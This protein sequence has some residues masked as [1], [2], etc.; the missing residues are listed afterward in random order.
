[1]NSLKYSPNTK[2]LI[3]T[4]LNHRANNGKIY[5]KYLLLKCFD[6]NNAMVI[7]SLIN[8]AIS[9]ENPLNVWG[10]GSAIR[11]FIYSEDV[12]KGM[13]QV[14]QKNYNK[15]VNLGSGK[16]VSIKKIANAVAKMV[17]GGPIKIIWDKTKPSGDKMRKMSTKRALSI[18]IKP[19]V[20]LEIGIKKT[21][22]WYKTK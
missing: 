17:P 19:S 13:L 2:L 9:G 8:R 14:V 5:A 1:M 11:D 7:P 4:S 6:P 18:N 15:P 21:I 22:D 12:A 16:G 10:D 3:I 20:K